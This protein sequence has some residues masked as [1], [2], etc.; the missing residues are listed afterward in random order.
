MALST[1]AFSWL[2]TIPSLPRPQF[3]KRRGRLSFSA[4]T[5]RPLVPQEG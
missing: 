4:R 5:H 2:H 3:G 1:E